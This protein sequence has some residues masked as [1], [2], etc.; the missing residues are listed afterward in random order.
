MLL[1]KAKFYFTLAKIHLLIAFLYQFY[2]SLY[3]Y[4][5]IQQFNLIFLLSINSLEANIDLIL[6]KIY[7]IEGQ[8]Y[9][10]KIKMYEL[11]AIIYI[12][13]DKIHLLTRLFSIAHRPP[14]EFKS[15]TAPRWNS[16][17]AG[18]RRNNQRAVGFSTEQPARSG[19]FN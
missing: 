19:F 11:K 3:I 9:L 12:I 2:I 10:I 7:L 5:L 1:H 17:S 18:G 13:K 6:V 4:A 14:V 15:P 16:T 8:F